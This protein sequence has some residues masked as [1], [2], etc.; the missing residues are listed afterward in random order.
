MSYSGKIGLSYSRCALDI[1]LGNVQ[2]SDVLFILAS[3]AIKSLDD[4]MVEIMFSQACQLFSSRSENIAALQNKA[5]AAEFSKV[6]YDLWVNDKIMQPRIN[7]GLAP[8]HTLISLRAIKESIDN[9]WVDLTLSYR[10]K[11][12]SVQAAYDNYLMLKK[13]SE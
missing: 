7:R 2:S 5:L 3:T 12:E 4:S 6:V 11:N 10:G 13:L 1:A 8:V 9:I